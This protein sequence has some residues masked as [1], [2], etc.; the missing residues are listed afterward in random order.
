MKRA[1]YFYTVHAQLESTGTTPLR[2][3]RTLII[4][5]IPAAAA[6]THVTRARERE[7]FFE[8]QNLGRI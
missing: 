8:P 6:A 3:A 2:H 5:R 1:L 7:Y 4:C